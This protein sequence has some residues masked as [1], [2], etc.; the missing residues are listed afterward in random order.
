[1]KVRVTPD[2]TAIFH[3]PG[4]DGYHGVSTDPANPNRLTGSRWSWNG[5]LEKPT[6]HPSVLV[7]P[8]ETVRVDI[9]DGLRGEDLENFLRE[10]RVMT[11][12]CHSH[13]R[14][15]RIEFCPDSEHALAGQTVDL[16]DLD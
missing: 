4:C 9:P 8:H 16:P 5:S 12:R 14:D 2:G 6:F 15:G 3:C 13:V 11:P 10:H 1:M 7:H